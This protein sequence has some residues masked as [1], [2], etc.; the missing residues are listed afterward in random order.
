MLAYFHINS[1]QNEA[2][3]SIYITYIHCYIIII[4]IIIYLAVKQ[5]VSQTDRSVCVWEKM[6]VLGC[7]GIF[8]KSG[9]VVIETQQDGTE[10]HIFV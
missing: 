6:E 2:S 1:G 8:Q 4:I 3:D 9:Q 10:K 7:Q 5:L